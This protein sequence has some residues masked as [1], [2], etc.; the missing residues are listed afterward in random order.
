MFNSWWNDNDNMTV[1]FHQHKDKLPILRNLNK[2][3]E[4]LKIDVD[5]IYLQFITEE[6]KKR[7]EFYESKD[8]AN[9]IKENQSKLIPHN[10]KNEYQ[11]DEISIERDEQK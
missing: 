9:Y 3:L 2:S 8:F 5:K 11:E 4:Q 10:E 1:I 7:K 6:S